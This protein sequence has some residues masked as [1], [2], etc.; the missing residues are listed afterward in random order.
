VQ[1]VG[2]RN[3]GIR[4]RRPLALAL[5]RKG[6]WTEKRDCIDM[7]DKSRTRRV[8]AGSGHNLKELLQLK[9]FVVI[10]E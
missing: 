7:R 4:K 3:V 9:L 10:I 2:V 8:K 5:D 1:S 6:P